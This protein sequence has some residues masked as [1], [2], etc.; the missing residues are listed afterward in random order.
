MIE[1]WIF[2]FLKGTGKLLLNPVFYYLFFVAAFLGVSRVRRER[3]D[4]SVRA[5]NAYFE[6]RQLLP[7]GIL[8][9][10]SVSVVMVGAG[11]VVPV[12]TIV[13]TAA[14][15]FLWSF[16][17][18][19][20]WMAPVYTLGFAFFA[21]MFAAEQKWPLPSFAQSAA[22]LDSSI[23][24][25]IAVLLALLVIAEGFLIIRNGR[26]GTSPRL[27]KSK[28]GQ[29]IGIHESKRIWMVP[30]F[31]L[32]PGQ[33]LQLPFDWWPV[34]PIGGEVYSLILVPFSIGFYQ[35]I[36]G[37]LPK[38]ATALLGQR[39]CVF[40]VLLLL[41]SSAGYWYPLASVGAAAL[42]I[43]GREFISLR[44]RMAED[45]A[46][47]YFSKR[48]Q[49]IMVLGVVPDS[50]A[51]KMSL[52]VGEV[53]TKV[54]G[55]KIHNEKGFYEALQKNGAHCKLE[56]LDVNGQ[57]RFVQRALYEGDHHELG[58]LFVQEEKKWDS[59]AV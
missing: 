33:A 55:V 52:Q 49:G 10:L 36:Q 34:I 20:R 29:T 30:V 16:T 5:E 45:Q 40:G 42:A 59:E 31:L 26:K 44:Q 56:V 24:P 13:L 14:L 2:E 32:I 8:A 38:E 18:K 12:E 58:L 27:V 28:R 11:L 3:K 57:V 48:N 1:E 19:V 50:P 7:L 4:F 51:Y 47:S 6:L 25:S 41:I 46:P 21:T 23:F 9:G 17:A 22:D 39:I 15:T 43:I 35:R 53:V 37:T 54:N